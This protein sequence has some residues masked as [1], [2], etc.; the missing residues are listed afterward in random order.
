MLNS[1]INLFLK[2]ILNELGLREIEIKIIIKDNSCTLTKLASLKIESY[3]LDIMKSL[4]NHTL[5]FTNI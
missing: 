3:L 1:L 5:I 4:K 2:V